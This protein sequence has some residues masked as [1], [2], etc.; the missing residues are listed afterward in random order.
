M[1][2]MSS[3]SSDLSSPPHVVPA[4]FRGKYSFTLSDKGSLDNQGGVALPSSRLPST[5]SKQGHRRAGAHGL[6]VEEKGGFHAHVGRPWPRSMQRNVQDAY[7]IAR[8]LPSLTPRFLSYPSCG[9]DPI[10]SSHSDY[11]FFSECNDSAD[12]QGEEYDLESMDIHVR[13]SYFEV[14][15]ERGRWMSSPT[16]SSM[17]AQ[18]FISSSSRAHSCTPD[19]H[20]RTRRLSTNSVTCSE[21]SSTSFLQDNSEAWDGSRCSSP[22]PSSSPP[23]SPMSFALS[24]PGDPPDFEGCDSGDQALSVLSDSDHFS[25]EVAHANAEEPCDPTSPD[26]S[27]PHESAVLPLPRYTEL[28]QHEEDAQLL[29]VPVEA[30][31]S[32]DLSP[33]SPFA[34]TNCARRCPLKTNVQVTRQLRQSSSPLYILVQIPDV[35]HRLKETVPPRFYYRQKR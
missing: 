28:I 17:H 12:S 4:K 31:C 34:Q 6:G 11:D 24:L 14:S 27:G 2:T 29:S 1:I 22:L 3:T 10:D 25:S 18:T 32:S 13:E 30:G 7:V 20:A 19:R 26:E 33:L 35:F 23:T 15:E 9:E 21:V 16:V 8:P 5:P